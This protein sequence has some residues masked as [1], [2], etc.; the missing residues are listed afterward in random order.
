MMQ[1]LN[2][3]FG[4]NH[5]NWLKSAPNVLMGLTLLSMSAILI[6]RPLIAI[7]LQPL[8]G[9]IYTTVLDG[10]DDTVMFKGG[11]P[12]KNCLPG[13]AVTRVNTPQ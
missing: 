13:E 4:V 6:A 7:E 9:N 10:E 2:S 11:C 1:L 8:D 12:I 3:W 5:G